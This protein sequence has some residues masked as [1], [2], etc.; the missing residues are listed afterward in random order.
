MPTLL[1][2]KRRL[3]SEFIQSNKSSGLNKAK[4]EGTFQAVWIILE[5]PWMA[6]S[7]AIEL[8]SAKKYYNGCELLNM[9]RASSVGYGPGK[10]VFILYWTHIYYSHIEG[11][12]VSLYKQIRLPFVLHHVPP[13]QQTR[14][15][16]CSYPPCINNKAEMPAK[17]KENTFPREL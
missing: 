12:R 2:S 11:T 16:F 3:G 13:G 1:S 6:G 10:A 14:W 7:F 4:G 5:L 17:G 15:S 9:Y 8:P